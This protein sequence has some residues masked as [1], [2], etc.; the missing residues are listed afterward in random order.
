M[1]KER[2]AW[3]SRNLLQKSTVGPSEST[4]VKPE[5]LA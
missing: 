5:N 3:F 1:K 4:D 2:P